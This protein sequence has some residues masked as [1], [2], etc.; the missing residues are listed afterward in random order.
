MAGEIATSDAQIDEMTEAAINAI[1]RIVQ[2]HVG[3]QHGDVAGIHFSDN[4]VR[5]AVR[6]IVSD[7]LAAEERAA[8]G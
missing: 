1:A 7:Y 3:Q 5:G 8:A 4:H 2:S 6:A